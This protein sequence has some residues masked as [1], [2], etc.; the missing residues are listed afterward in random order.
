MERIL[1]TDKERIEELEAKL[2]GVAITMR[3]GPAARIRELEAKLAQVERFLT[4]E[5]KQIIAGLNAELARVEKERD[6][7]KLIRQS[8]LTHGVSSAIP[9]VAPDDQRVVEA[10]KCISGEKWCGYKFCRGKH[11]K[12]LAAFA[13][14]EHAKRVEAEARLKELEARR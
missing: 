11:A 3:E 5:D 4:G 1:I 2:A 8:D 10:L 9:T 7:L 13:R 6:E 12:V 14:S